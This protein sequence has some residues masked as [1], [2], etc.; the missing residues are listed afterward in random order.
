MLKF[1]KTSIIVFIIGLMLAAF[2]GWEYQ[3][4]IQG[5]LQALF[6]AFVLSILEVSISFDNAVVNATVLKRMTPEWQHRFITWGMLIAVFGMRIIFPL[7]VVS[8]A[9]SIS[10]WEAL[11]IATF[12]PD[13]YSKLMLQAHVPVSAFGGAFLMMV[14]LKYFFDSGKEVHWIQRIEMPLAKLGKIESVEIGFVLISIL[15]LMRVLPEHDQV[16][17][18]LA[19]IAGLITYIAVDGLSGFLSLSDKTETDI[20]KTSAMLFV[21][22]EVLDASF[23]F[24]GVIGAFAITNNLFIIAI[25]LGIGA[26]FVRSLTIMF[27][28]KNTLTEFKYL[29]HGAFYAIWALAIIMFMNTLV[30]IPEVVTGVFGATFIGLAL[31]SSLRERSLTKNFHSTP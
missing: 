20:Q 24:D 19:G 4:S 30:E 9:A 7:I 10:P 8:I 3:H 16:P 6:L 31:R 2:V 29:E 15:S 26:M 28:E 21:Y 27:V 13:D 22:L 5:A 14:S 11:K 1:F 17:F 18:V 25:G 12:S 23:S